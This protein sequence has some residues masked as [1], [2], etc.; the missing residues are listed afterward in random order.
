MCI[1]KGKKTQWRQDSVPSVVRAFTG[2]LGVYALWVRGR[3]V[4]GGH[5]GFDM[6]VKTPVDVLTFLI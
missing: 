2:G 4:K 6:I 1:F 5:H 3:V